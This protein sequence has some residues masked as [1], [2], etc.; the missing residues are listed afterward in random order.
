MIVLPIAG[1][2]QQTFDAVMAV[3]FLAIGKGM[4]RRA[5]LNQQRA[6]REQ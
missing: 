1:M 4:R 3:G 2:S 6:E 5:E